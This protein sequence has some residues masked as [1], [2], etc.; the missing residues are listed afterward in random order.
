MPW[1]EWDSAIRRREPAAVEYYRQKL[2]AEIN[3][4]AFLQFVFWKQWQELKAY[5]N[6]QGIRL[7]G[8]LPLFVAHDSADVW[9]KPDLFALDAAGSPVKVAGVPPDYFSATGQ[10]W[11]N[12][13]YDWENM[14]RDDYRWW[15]DRLQVLL[16]LVDVIRI[17]HFRGF[18]AYWEIPAGD[19]T[20]ENGRWVAG[21]GAKF[22][23]VLEKY[24][25]KLPLVAEDLGVITA[26]VNR[27]KHKFGYP[28]MK[29][30]QFSF[31]DGGSEPDFP[32]NTG[33][34]TIA[35]TG[36]H[37][38]DTLLG[39]WQKL[40]IDNPV[41]RG[42]VSKHLARLKLGE[43][44]SDAGVCDQLIRL[45][46]LSRA[47]TVILP[48]QDVL[49]LDTT[50]RMNTPGTVGDNWGWRLPPGLLTEE[51]AGRLAGW[52]A[53]GGRDNHHV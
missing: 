32:Y 47:D 46:Y 1:N 36:T 23:A 40:A 37:D 45:T 18:E 20:A 19:Q 39:W 2:Q 48:L 14:A 8:D 13:L 12:P 10:L 53:L 24:L 49:G 35:Y 27:L 52:A 42:L 38:N 25:G 15:R 33:V 7:F 5:A 6:K 41:L 17:D 31:G 44:W 22:F 16:T 11:G 43:N 51:V 34:N 30:L 3:Y 50:A 9:A 4:Q 28:G 21:P 29:V 26:G